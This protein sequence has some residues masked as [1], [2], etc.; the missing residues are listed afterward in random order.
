MSGKS[1]LKPN[2]NYPTLIYQFVDLLD[3]LSLTQLVTTTTTITL[4]L[5]I[6]NNPRIVTACGV[7]PGVSDHDAVLTEINTKPLRNKQT[8][9]TPPPLHGKD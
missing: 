3:V 9:R 7:M 6:T 5:V 1:C 2:Y 8:P 4:N